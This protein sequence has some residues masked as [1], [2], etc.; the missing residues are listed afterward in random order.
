MKIERRT[1]PF[2][3]MENAATGETAE[4]ASRYTHFPRSTATLR[5]MPLSTYRFARLQGLRMNAHGLP[6][7][8]GLDVIPPATGVTPPDLHPLFADTDILWVNGVRTPPA[9]RQQI[10]THMADTLG[11]PVYL[12]HNPTEGMAAD[13]LEAYRELY[14][15]TP[16]PVTRQL[17]QILVQRMLTWR[18]HPQAPGITLIGHSQG[19]IQ[20]VHAVR[21]AIDQLRLHLWLAATTRARMLGSPLPPRDRL[22]AVIDAEIRAMLSHKLRIVLTGSPVDPAASHQPITRLADGTPLSRFLAV[23][24]VV[25]HPSVYQETVT[26]NW[27]F[28]RHPADPVATLIRRLRPTAFDS[29]NG[30]IRSAHLQAH[31]FRTVYLPVLYRILIRSR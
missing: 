7:D 29:P 2:T 31:D 12:L 9:A 17:T 16:T 20:I 6:R 27:I 21:D 19:S 15:G 28:L 25:L 26:G 18:A 10:A 5:F 3:F 1:N 22:F 11:R 13:L 30:P 4:T 23:Q 24:D 14:T 8:T